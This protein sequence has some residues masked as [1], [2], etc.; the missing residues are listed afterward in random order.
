MGSTARLQGKKC[1]E[2]ISGMSSS[3]VRMVFCQENVLDDSLQKKRNMD[4]AMK[5]TPEMK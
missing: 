3:G 1:L 5:A 4:F 2:E